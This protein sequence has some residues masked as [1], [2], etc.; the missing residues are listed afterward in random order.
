VL[1][2]VIFQDAPALAVTLYV[3]VLVVSDCGDAAL[4]SVVV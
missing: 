4:I 2:K 3:L 1:V